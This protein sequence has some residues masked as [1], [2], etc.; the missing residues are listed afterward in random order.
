MA[1]RSLKAFG[2][3]WDL[4]VARA[5]DALRV[6]VRPQG[7]QVQEYRVAPGGAIEVDLP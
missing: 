2:R 1:L 6:T 4:E 3:T 7:G 5:G